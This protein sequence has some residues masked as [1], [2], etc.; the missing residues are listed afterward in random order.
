M[1]ARDARSDIS[2]LL[3]A[4]RKKAF[5]LLN[6][7]AEKEEKGDLVEARSAYLSAQE[8]LHQG[9]YQYKMFKE[10]HQSKYEDANLC[11]MS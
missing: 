1:E 6:Q 7:A 10:Q 2:S 8:H 5:R 3:E 4:E 9:L 11:L